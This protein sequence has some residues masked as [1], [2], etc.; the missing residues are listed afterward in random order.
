MAQFAFMRSPGA[1]HAYEVG[2][3]VEVYCD[4]KR[5]VNVYAAG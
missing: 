2:D 1:E 3:T 5:A 4:T